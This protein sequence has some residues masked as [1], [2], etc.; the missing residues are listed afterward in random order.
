MAY[1]ALWIINSYVTWAELVKYI[2]VHSIRKSPSGSKTL[3]IE[4]ENKIKGIRGNGKIILGCIHLRY[5][6]YKPVF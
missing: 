4:A 3:N 1:L 2:D 6:Q 5:S